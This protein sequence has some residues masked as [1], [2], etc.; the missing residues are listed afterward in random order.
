MSLSL[1]SAAPSRRQAASSPWGGELTWT[2][3]LGCLSLGI[4]TIKKALVQRVSLH[5]RLSPGLGPLDVTI[6]RSLNAKAQSTKDAEELNL[7]PWGVGVTGWCVE[8]SVQQM[9]IPSS[10][11]RV[12]TPFRLC[13]QFLL[14]RCGLDHRLGNGS[15]RGSKPSA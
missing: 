15:S 13:V 11:L 2:E 9:E 7:F 4:Q 1:L 3:T 6:Q 12:L 8:F 14:L 10:R 5:Q